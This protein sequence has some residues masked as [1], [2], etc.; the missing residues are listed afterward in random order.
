MLI[1][2]QIIITGPLHTE[3]NILYHMFCGKYYRQQGKSI[4]RLS[5]QFKDQNS[6]SQILF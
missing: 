6:L 1:N 3:I 2:T 4:K 5:V